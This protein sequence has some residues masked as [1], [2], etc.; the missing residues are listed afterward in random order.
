MLIHSLKMHIIIFV[1]KWLKPKLPDFNISIQRA[2]KVF[3]CCFSWKAW[4]K[5]QLVSSDEWQYTRAGCKTTWASNVDFVPEV[6]P[7]LYFN[8]D[9]PKNFLIYLSEKCPVLEKF[10]HVIAPR[11]NSSDV[12]ITYSPKTADADSMHE[13]YVA[14][15]TESLRTQQSVQSLLSL[16]DGLLSGDKEYSPIFYHLKNSSLHAVTEHERLQVQSFCN[17]LD[18]KEGLIQSLLVDRNFHITAVLTASD[19]RY[20]AMMYR[21]ICKMIKRQFWPS[22]LQLVNSSCFSVLALKCT[23]WMS[24]RD[25]VLLCNI[26]HAES[27]SDSIKLLMQLWDPVVRTRA[28]LGCLSKFSSA[29]CIHLLKQIQQEGSLPSINNE[30]ECLLENQLD[31]IIVLNDVSSVF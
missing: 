23:L 21:V 1:A 27:A 29:D 3:N 11:P 13:I 24:V 9:L 16:H 25:F 19:P 22:L 30:L 4:H 31:K 28:V 5:R 12:H 18:S 15:I 10:V 7:S 26:H 20:E 17:V 8:F 2:R 6:F 14:D